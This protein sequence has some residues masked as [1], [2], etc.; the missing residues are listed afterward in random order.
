MHAFAH[1]GLEVRSARARHAP[2]QLETLI[3]RGEV[4]M[5]AAL[6]GRTQVGLAVLYLRP[7]ADVLALRAGWGRLLDPLVAGS[8]LLQPVV[9]PEHPRRAAVAEALIDDAIVHARRAGRGSV[10]LHVRASD[11]DRL[12][13]YQAL[14]FEMVRQVDGPD[15]L[16]VELGLII[17]RSPRRWAG[18]RAVPSMP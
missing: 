7:S 15:D 8:A 1:L 14:R 6:S 3:R 12:D 9:I 17:R 4:V 5:R 16:Y 2:A 11:R 10:A 18:S 13:L